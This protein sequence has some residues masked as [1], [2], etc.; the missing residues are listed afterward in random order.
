MTERKAIQKPEEASLRALL[1][2]EHGNAAATVL[3]LAWQAGLQRR[4]ICGLTWANVKLDAGSIRLPD[5]VIPLTEELLRYLGNL[6]DSQ[7]GPGAGDRVV[8]SDRDQKPMALYSISNLARTALQTAGMEGITL[9]DLRMDYIL[10]QIES[11]GVEHAARVTGMDVAWLT[12]LAEQYL[13]AGKKRSLKVD[14]AGGCPDISHAALEELVHREGCTDGALAAYLALDA[15]A[16]LREIAEL[17]WDDVDLRAGTL[18]LA[19]RTVRLSPALAE[20]LERH[21]APT[22]FVLTTPKTG[23]AYP[24]ERISRLVRAALVRAGLDHLSLKDL[25]NAHARAEAVKKLTDW[26]QRNGAI[27]RSEAAKLL[28]MTETAVGRLLQSLSGDGVFT[29]VGMKYYLPGTVVPPEEQRGRVLRLL[30]KE[31]SAS[32]A[33]FAVELK[34]DVRQCGTLLRHMVRDGDIVQVGRKYQL[35]GELSINNKK[36]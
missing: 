4:E 28:N 10:R 12:H 24:T 30:E 8:L 27:K 1:N 3:R 23:K 32:C 9:G 25:N 35:P 26:I 20:L 7:G 14:H 21:R 34:T 31:R 22:E 17:R 18:T 6:R 15:G 29:V 5:R 36:M 19:D 13:P 33:A 11:G 2:R 16:G